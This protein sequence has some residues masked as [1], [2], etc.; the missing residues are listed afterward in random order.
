MGRKKMAVKD[1]KGMLVVDLEKNTSKKVSITSFFRIKSFSPDDTEI[2]IDTLAT[3]GS[4]NTMLYDLSCKCKQPTPLVTENI[5]V[6]WRSQGIYGYRV[7]NPQ[8]SADIEFLNLSTGAP[9]KKFN[10]ITGPWI[11]SKSTLAFVWVHSPNASDKG[12]LMSFDLVTQ[13]T[14]ELF[15][16]NCCLLSYNND[17]TRATLSPDGKKLAFTKGGYLRMINM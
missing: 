9:L 12:I 13:Q 11:G 5:A 8:T 14:K 7:L 6:T 17:V 3:S 1:G 10:Q 4:T 16:G 2:L 15:T